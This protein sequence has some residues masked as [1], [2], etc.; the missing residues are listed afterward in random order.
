M[1]M[2]ILIAPSGFKES[3]QAEEVADAIEQGIRNIVPTA[4]IIKLP[5]VDGGEGFARTLT[6]VTGGT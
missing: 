6:H 1:S 3:L 5:L 4:R 2:R